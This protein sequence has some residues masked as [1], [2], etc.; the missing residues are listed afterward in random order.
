MV[1]EGV[2]AVNGK[3]SGASPLSV[4]CFNPPSAPAG[5]CQAVNTFVARCHVAITTKKMKLKQDRHCTYN[6]I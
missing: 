5:L 2:D 6:E 1:V 4:Y 3:D